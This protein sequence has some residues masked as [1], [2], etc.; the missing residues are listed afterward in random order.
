MK[1]A[2]INPVLLTN[3]EIEILELVAKGWTA[4]QIS[5]ELNI[6]SRTV[7]RHLENSRLKTATKNRAHMVAM[8]VKEGWIFHPYAGI[9]ENR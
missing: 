2:A 9:S 5:V 8:A 4:K 1:H 3:R 7:E 6:A